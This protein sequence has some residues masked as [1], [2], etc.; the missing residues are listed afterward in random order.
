MSLRHPDHKKLHIFKT[1]NGKSDNW[2]SGFYWK[3]HFIRRS[4]GTEN[5][6]EAQRIAESWYEKKRYEVKHGLL[7]LSQ[8][9]CFSSFINAALDRFTKSHSPEYLKSLQIS[10]SASGPIVEFFGPLEVQKI[11]SSTWDEFR[12]FIVDKRFASGDAPWSEGTFHQQKNAVN[13][14]LKQAQFAKAISVVPKFTDLMKKKKQPTKPRVYFDSQEYL[15]LRT[16]ST[17]NIAWHKKTKSRWLSDAEELHDYIIFMV[18]TGL[19]VGESRKLVVR[20][21]KIVTDKRGEEACKITVRS[22]K[23]GPGTSV[24][25]VGAPAIFRRILTRRGITDP[26]TCIE[27]LFLKLHRGAFRRILDDLG[28]RRDGFGNKRD[29][30][31]L[32]HSYVCF[33]LTRGV[34]IQD[35][36]KNIRTSVAMIEKHYAAL[37]PP[38]AAALNRK[39]WEN[40][41]PEIIASSGGNNDEEILV[42]QA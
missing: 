25:F 24:S 35:I 6:S 36:A 20:D 26:E 1:P 15:Q 5:L 22:G 33:A 38:N 12:A 23:R 17:R 39:T 28:L 9:P 29:F 2:Y 16:A 40:S 21:V 41:R 19:R 7:K 31:S 10:L 13:A 37:L 8:G 42:P 32:R 27:P 3:G 11:D 34:A 14:V 4:T 18:N 30:V